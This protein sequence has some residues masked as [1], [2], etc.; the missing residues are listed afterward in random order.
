[1]RQLNEVQRKFLEYL[2]KEYNCLGYDISIPDALRTNTYSVNTM[3]NVLAD[4]KLFR[5]GKFERIDTIKI[6][7]NRKKPT[8][9]LK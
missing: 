5:V 9:Y 8:Q 6:L 1:M 3:N 2:Q 7:Y 4:W